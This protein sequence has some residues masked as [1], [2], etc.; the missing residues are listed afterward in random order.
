MV[1]EKDCIYKM[2]YFTNSCKLINSTLITEER[3]PGKPSVPPAVA[4]GTDR[5]FLLLFR[6]YELQ[7]T[8][9]TDELPGNCQKMEAADL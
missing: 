8:L 5:S 2:P 6:R 3:A 9:T 1:Q 4:G 7:L